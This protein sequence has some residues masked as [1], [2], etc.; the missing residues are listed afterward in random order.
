MIKRDIHRVLF[1]CVIMILQIIFDYYIN[2]GPYIYLCLIPLLIMY[3]PQGAS[4]IRVMITAFVFGLLT[5]ILCDGVLGL[6]AA[7]AVAAGAATRFAPIH[8]LTLGKEGGE[9]HRTPSVKSLGLSKFLKYS[10]LITLVY[11][12]VYILLDGGGSGILFM[13]LKSVATIVAN[14][15][16]Y[17]IISFTFTNED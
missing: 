11:T 15:T 17:L 8:S 12:L 4:A 9:K 1:F 2:L 10:L 16:L 14:M 6:N 13:I 3:L 5:D 7:A